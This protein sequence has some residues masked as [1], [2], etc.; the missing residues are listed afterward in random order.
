MMDVS[1]ALKATDKAWTASGHDL[2]ALSAAL[3]VVHLI[4]QLQLEVL[5]GSIYGWLINLGADGPATA[6]ALDSV[7][8]HECAALVREALSFFPS[9]TPASGDRERVQPMEMASESDVNRWRE[10]G[11]RL[12]EWPDDIHA[13]LQAYITAHEED[14][15]KAERDPPLG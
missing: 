12:L 4:D 11:A 8:A 1:R 9:G 2:R 14:F 15:V 6:A 3:Q 10:L 7:G 5:L 13:L